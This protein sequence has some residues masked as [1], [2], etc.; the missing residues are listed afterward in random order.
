MSCQVTCYDC[1]IMRSR[2]LVLAVCLLALGLVS[3]ARAQE[4][5]GSMGGESFSSG[6]SGGGSDSGS[7]SYDSRS[8]SYS[9]GGSSSSGG[10]GAGD[11]QVFL[12]VFGGLL[13][14]FLVLAPF[15]KSQP[16][17]GTAGAEMFLSWLVLGIDWHARRELQGTLAALATRKLGGTAEG[18]AR[19]LREVVLA[20]ERAELSWLYVACDQE[21]PARAAKAQ[22]AFLAA[23]HKARSRFRR[24]LIRS[25]GGELATEAAGPMESRPEEGAGTVVV[26]LI[27]VTR[28]PVAGRTG[29]TDA[30]EISAA[31][32][33]RAGVTSQELVAIEIVWSPAAED[34]RMSTAELEQHY[35]EL[36]LIDPESI[37]GR[38]FCSYCGG[39]FAMELLSCPHCG[40]AVDEG[41]RTRQQGPHG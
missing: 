36:V 20:L 14:V 38:I 37:A 41:D 6:S 33:D 15:A 27:L 35:P 18:R 5:G 7:S 25:E 19:M 10:G 2:F 8:S 34:D 4:T 24:E 23:C 29:M 31:L 39:V 12:Y 22:S 3:L 9:G 13:V 26:S 30:G 11:G 40:A 21:P 16:A 28:Q 17:G 1:F 32:A